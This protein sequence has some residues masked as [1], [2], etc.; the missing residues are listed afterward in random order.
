VDVGAVA[1]PSMVT[2]EQVADVKK[3]I[4]ISAAE[5]DAVFPEQKRHET[6]DKLKEI[7]AT[8]TLQL[9]SQAQH[10]FAVRGDLKKPMIKFA[11]EKA[12][13]QAVEWFK[14]HM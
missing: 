5:T 1:H 10:G 9:F 13:Q 14:F 2:L 7:G 6:E 4:T 3:P 12:F 11:K 8:Y